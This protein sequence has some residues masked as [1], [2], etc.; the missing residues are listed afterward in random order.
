MPEPLD[1]SVGQVHQ[2]LDDLG[3]AAY[4]VLHSPAKVG[5]QPPENARRVRQKFE[6]NQARGGACRVLMVEPIST[7]CDALQV[8]VDTSYQNV[9]WHMPCNRGL[10]DSVI[11]LISRSSSAG[12][13]PHY[14]PAV[15]TM[16]RDPASNSTN[17]ACPAA[18]R[19]RR[20]R[21][22]AS[23]TKPINTLGLAMLGVSFFA[24]AILAGTAFTATH[25]VEQEWLH[26]KHQKFGKLVALLDFEAAFGY[27]GVIHSL[28]NYV[29]RGKQVDRD[30]TLAALQDARDA[31]AVYRSLGDLS[32][33]ESE[34]LRALDHLVAAYAGSL[35]RIGDRELSIAATDKV[36]FVDDTRYARAIDQLR[37]IV[38]EESDQAAASLQSTMATGR[39][40]LLAIVTLVFGTLSVGIYFLIKMTSRAALTLHNRA[41]SISAFAKRS[42]SA[43]IRTDAAGR[44]TWANEGFEQLCGF[45][46]EECIGRSPGAM[47]QCEK[48]DPETV[49]AIRRALASGEGYRGRILNRSKSGQDYWV[50]ME[51]MPETDPDEVITG[52]I[53]VEV[54]VTEIVETHQRFSLAVAGSRDAILDWNVDRGDVYY[55]PRWNELLQL[56]GMELEPTM[57]TL[58]DFVANDDIERVRREL[59]EYLASDLSNLESEFRM[60]TLDGRL[61]SVLLRV[62]A[63][64]RHDGVPERVCGSV[65]DITSLKAAEE[66]MRSL[67]EQDHLTGLASRSR[68]TACLED[69]LARSRRSGRHCGVLFM[70][71]DHFKVV[72]DSLGHE[73]GDQL[74]CSVAERLRSSIRDIDTAA[75]FGGD[76]FVV[77]LEGLADSS[78]AEEVAHKLLETCAQPHSIEGNRLVSTASIGVVTT[79]LVSECGADM[80]RAADA[81]M[82]QANA[83]G[84]GCAVVFDRTMHE[85]NL[86]RLALEQDIRHTLETDEFVPYFQPIVNLDTGEPVGAEALARWMH[87]R[88]GP[89]SPGVF[90]PI[91]EESNQICAL[92]TCIL[93]KTCEQIAEW[94]RRRVVPDGFTVSVNASKAQLIASVTPDHL[95]DI[96]SRSGIQP[97][98]LKLEVTETTIVDNR[99]GIAEVLSQLRERGYLVMMDD[100]GTGQ[101]SLSGLHTLPI[102]ELKIDQSFIR[103]GQVTKQ[104]VAIA[105]AIVTLADHLSLRTIG[106]GIESSDHVALLLTL[107][108]THGQ[109]YLFSKPLPADD[110]EAWLKGGLHRQAA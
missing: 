40:V 88:R 75:R 6:T 65:A 38:R 56:E 70:D 85:Q 12:V 36:A 16:T 11:V 23:V 61:I 37:T 48:T 100:F 41:E 39:V 42:T 7:E 34:Q 1:H 10:D 109:G 46:F 86:E 28:K 25:W 57:S 47:L 94:K 31:L 81:A 101:S 108:C 95:D 21:R 84:R 79:E 49:E 104:L 26:M 54:D 83:R 24:L 69:A 14:A 96:V 76:E 43:M 35:A 106:E 20:S 71:F 9:A 99:S 22:G 30:Q 74:L 98:D 53:A 5:V 44:I 17:I 60:R 67:V 72:N 27:E 107:G 3:L 90:V 105:S 77:L 15:R 63:H 92:G 78:V 89:V 58:F 8:D 59:D 32:E 73:I 51:I 82:Y 50:D 64:R 13:T 80:I 103:H 66:R 62:A 33:A 18:T 52:F 91:A 29:L 110:F 87:P 4:S 102:D 93:R 68:L 55:S 45:T 2:T 19:G 97:A